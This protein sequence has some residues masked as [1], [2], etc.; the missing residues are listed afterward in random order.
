M[1]GIAALAVKE[2]AGSGLLSPSTVDG[3]AVGTLLSALCLLMAMGPRRRLRRAR[4]ARVAPSS[5]DSLS[6]RAAAIPARSDCLTATAPGPLTEVP[7]E[8]AAEAVAQ[9]VTPGREEGAH[10]TDG[11]DNARR[12]KHRLSGPD[13]A[14]RQELGRTAPRHAAPAHRIG[15]MASKAPLHPVAARD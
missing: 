15:R 9:A 11:K 10:A 8:V 6:S 13:A 7:V 14:R 4:R 2:A 3:F 5:R 1:Y 12:S